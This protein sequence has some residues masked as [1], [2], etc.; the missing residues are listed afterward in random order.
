[1]AMI[2]ETPLPEGKTSEKQGGS[3]VFSDHESWLLTASKLMLVVDGLSVLDG[4][5]AYGVRMTDDGVRVWCM[6]PLDAVGRQIH[7]SGV[8]A[9]GTI[10]ASSFHLPA[11]RK[12]S[13]LFDHPSM[14][15]ERTKA[16]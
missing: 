5:V 11:L 9:S 2:D 15:P 12:Y 8:E 10:N 13:A 3:S 14:T 16:G 6:D 7:E 1:M 4:L